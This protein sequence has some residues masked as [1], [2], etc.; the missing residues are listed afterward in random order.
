MGREGVSDEMGGFS[1]GKVLAIGG[2]EGQ[3]PIFD[4]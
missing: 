2:V 1:D 3:L 4:V